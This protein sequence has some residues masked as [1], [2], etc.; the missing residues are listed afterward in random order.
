MQNFWGIYLLSLIACTQLFGQVAVEAPI[1]LAPPCA[2]S[3]DRPTKTHAVIVG[4]SQYRY[5]GIYLNDLST[6]TKDAS[7]FDRFLLTES[8]HGNQTGWV[9]LLTD[10]QA[11]EGNIIHSLETMNKQTEPDDVAIFFFSGHGTPQGLTHYETDASDIME[12]EGLKSLLH[13]SPA[14]QVIVILDACHAGS[15]TNAHYMGQVSDLLGGDSNQRMCF[16]SSSAAEESSLEYE[17]EGMGYF[18]YYFI[19]ALRGESDPNHDGCI[20]LREAFDTAK[21]NVQLG[22]IWA[23]NPTLTGDVPKNFVL[24]AH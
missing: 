1:K 4:I 13:A 16:I 7:E 19:R 12:Y 17:A 9:D 10:E 14:K 6:P 3:G 23:Q 22:T 18:A 2:L 5:G 21:L 15:S 11:T 8:T 24:W 20:T